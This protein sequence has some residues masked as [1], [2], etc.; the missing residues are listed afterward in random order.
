LLFYAFLEA[1]KDH[2]LHLEALKDHHL[3]LQLIVQMVL[4]GTILLCDSV[5]ASSSCIENNNEN[6]DRRVKIIDDQR[7]C[8]WEPIKISRGNL[9]YVPKSTQ[10]TSL[11]TRF[12]T[13]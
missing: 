2:H 4:L 10:H 12:K 11:L 1:K 5:L 3:E 6:G 7:R 13:T 8:E 9:A